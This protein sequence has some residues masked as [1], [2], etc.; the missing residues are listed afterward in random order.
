[1]LKLRLEA[2]EKQGECSAILTLSFMIIVLSAVSVSLMPGVYVAVIRPVI[3][4]YENIISAV[5]SVILVTFSFVLCRGLS[6]GADRFMLKRA[7]NSATGAGDIFYYLAPKRAFGMFWFALRFALTKL[8]I[9]LGLLTPAIICGYVFYVI[10][11]AGFSAAVCSIFGAFTIIFVL[12]ALKTYRDICDS[13]ILVRYRFIKGTALSFGNL[14]SQSQTDMKDEIHNL[15]KLRRSF[16]GW[17]I[18]SLLIFPIPYVW[19]YYRQ[20]LACF[21]VKREKVVSF[22]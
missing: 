18:L 15:R 3:T 22:S 14:L 17:F 19:S 11:S 10:S 9:F 2:R 20:T 12:S 7:E 16:A 21:A 1:M 13:Y 6:L 4:S 5:L 8:V